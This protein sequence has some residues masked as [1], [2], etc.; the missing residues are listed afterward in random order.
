[1]KRVP[2]FNKVYNILFLINKFTCVGSG[3][4]WS[5]QDEERG[6]RFH[7]E[8]LFRLDDSFCAANAFIDQHLLLQTTVDSSFCHMLGFHVWE[9]LLIGVLLSNSK[10]GFVENDD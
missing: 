5:Q 3:G 10:N 2:F 8:R 1:M 4:G 6:G 9:L 7:R